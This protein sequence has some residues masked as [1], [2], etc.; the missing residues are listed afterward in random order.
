MDLP[1]FQC[2]LQNVW[3]LKY[4]GTPLQQVWR[5]LK[6]LKQQLKDKCLHGHIQAKT[7]T[8]QRV[9]G[10]VLFDADK[11]VLEDIEKW[12]TVE[13]QVMR[14]KSKAC[15]I[16]CGDANAKYFHAQWKI[17][18]SQSN[19]TS[20]YTDTGLKLI[21]PED[22]EQEFIT[23]F[24]SLM[25]DCERELP[26]ANTAIIREGKC[27]SRLQQTMLIQ[28]VIMEE[29]IETIKEMPKDKAPGVDGFPV[30]FFTKNW[31]IVKEDI[32]AVVKDFSYD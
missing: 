4:N 22:V 23:V 28:E 20:I 29:V 19:I 31:D 1:Q 25:G 7:C 2:I 8:G 9:S 27:L 13:E 21:E 11:A 5:K 10:H 30:E 16:A 6:C 15:R 3:R 26:L 32:F 12:S 24:Q 14:H 17:K 18:T